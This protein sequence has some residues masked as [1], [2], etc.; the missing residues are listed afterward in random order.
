[1]QLSIII[2][3]RTASNLIPCVEA[4]HRLE[5]LANMTIIDDGI[6]NSYQLALDMFEE[7]VCFLNG[8][9][10]FIFSRAVNQGI[11]AT[12]ANDICICNDDA[13]LQ[14]PGGFT[15]MQKLAEEHREY[16]IISATTNVVGNPNQQPKGIGLREEPR[17][18]AFVCVLIPRRTI[19]AVGLLD[20][21][22]DCYSHQDDDMCRRVRNAGLKIGIFDGCYVDHG[23][24]RSTFRGDPF[25]P[26]DTFVGSQIYQQKWGDLN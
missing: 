21:R 25:A 1:M 8:I 12:G 7:D 17:M 6:E 9:K 24:L 18:V 19:D 5:P 11:L 23:S 15:A 10:P 20:E 26:G 13:I 16:G 3:S 4:I 22:F 2:P 14:T